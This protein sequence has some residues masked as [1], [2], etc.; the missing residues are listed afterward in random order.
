MSELHDEYARRIR[1][2]GVTY[3][4][5]HVPEVR[6][7]GQYTDEHARAREASAL[8]DCL[9]PRPG[10][11][12]AVERTGEELDSVALAS[13]LRRWARPTLTLLVGGPAGLDRGLLARADARWSLSRLTFPHELARL[14]VAEQLYR[15][16]TLLRGI[17]YHR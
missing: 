6:A 11:L 16:L 15:A 7:G 9:G 3:E 2:L 14:L 1:R 5:H 17:P 12:V 8:A 10:T 4:A 13:R